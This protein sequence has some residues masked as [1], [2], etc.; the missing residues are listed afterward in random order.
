MKLSQ[1]Q[2]FIL[3]LFALVVVCLFVFGIGL[4][5]ITYRPQLV[6]ENVAPP[7]EVVPL[8]PKFTSSSVQAPAPTIAFTPTSTQL[9]NV[10]FTPFV[11]TTPT[12]WIVPSLTPIPI[13]RVSSPIPNP[14]QQNPPQQNPPQQNTNQ[15]AN[16][17]PQLNY[18]KSTHQYN[19]SRIDSIYS[20]L[21]SYYENLL[22]QALRDRDA[23]AVNQYQRELNSQ[24]NQYNAAVKAENQRYAGEIA[25]I[26][27]TCK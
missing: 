5:Y 6:L 12:N 4:I 3:G 22:E 9:P 16:C 1:N 2:K 7:T 20:P 10:L 17:T 18:A 26:K 15:Q 24:K 27:S 25:N 21:I 8:L 14:Q 23:L 13:N 11:V 19:L